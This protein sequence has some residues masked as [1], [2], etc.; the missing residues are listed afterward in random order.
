MKKAAEVENFTKCKR[1]VHRY[2]SIEEG[3]ENYKKEIS[4]D[5]MAIINMDIFYTLKI[6]ICINKN[7]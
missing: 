2:F 3:Y 5:D 1:C 4:V 7:I 6:F